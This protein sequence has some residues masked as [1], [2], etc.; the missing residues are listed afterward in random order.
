MSDTRTAMLEARVAALESQLA[1][2]MRRRGTPFGLG[3]TIMAPD[4]SGVVQTV[5]VQFDAL[6]TR[7][8]VPVLYHHGFF[9]NPPVGSDVH[10]AFL[11]ADRSKAI[12]VATGNQA[13]R[14][15]G[16]ALG[17][18]GLHAQGLTL[19][20]SAS[21]FAF[22]GGPIA[23]TGD[24]HVSGATIAGFGGAGSVGLQTHTHPASGQPPTRGT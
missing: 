23:Q 17:D 24:L 1:L 8:A 20:L 5:Q 12:V 21:G 13:G 15:I 9:S 22:S 19:H 14:M 11:D 7:D 6:T 4:D 2:M 18:A 10:V 16:A 3:R